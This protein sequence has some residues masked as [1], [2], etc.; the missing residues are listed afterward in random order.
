L[1]RQGRL[2]LPSDLATHRIPVAI[3][4]VASTP[5]LKIHDPLELDSVI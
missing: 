1:A 5:L 2:S 3:A 4:A